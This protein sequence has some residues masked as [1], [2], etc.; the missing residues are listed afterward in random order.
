MVPSSL[1]LLQV[2]CM[3]TPG[4]TTNFTPLMDVW[5]VNMQFC[6][7]SSGGLE[8]TT[9]A[10]LAIQVR[11]GGRIYRTIPTASCAEYVYIYI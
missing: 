5:D 6:S 2:A 9:S 8:V 3:D 4:H 11:A 10:M 7:A 1:C